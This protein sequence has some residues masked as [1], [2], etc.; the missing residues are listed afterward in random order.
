MVWLGNVLIEVL[1]TVVYMFVLF[2]LWVVLNLCFMVLVVMSLT[3]KIP[4]IRKYL[5]VSNSYDT[6]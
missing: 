3:I 6:K 2:P 5:G 4:M 1:A